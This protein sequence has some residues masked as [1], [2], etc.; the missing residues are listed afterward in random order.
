MSSFWSGWVLILTLACLGLVIFILFATWKIQRKNTTEETVGHEFDGIVEYDNPM[1][2]WWIGLFLATLIFGGIY[3]VLYPGIFPGKFDGILGWTSIGELEGDQAKHKEQF[4]PLFS[5][6]ANMS[7]EE[8]QSEP[9][10]LNMGKRIFL[11]NCA[12]C[13]G[14]DAG[15]TFGFPSLTDD[16]WVWGGSADEIE[17]TV[18]DG[19]TGQMP[20]WG[21]VLGEK[22][23]RNVSLYARSLSGIDTGAT[24]K[25]LQAGKTAYD[26]TC[27]VCHGADGKGN[28]LFGAPNLTDDVWL[29]GS[30]QAQVE[31][32]VRKGRNG[33]M[34][35]WKD[36]LGK[37]KVHLVTGYVYSLTKDKK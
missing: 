31:Y 18:L 32:T 1:P 4:Q 17:T 12:L 22:G 33:V 20:A 3:F 14:S 21:P 10:A 29:F 8:L 34:P 16:D 19:R 5:K 27:A 25:E 30:S 2:M 15:G 36:V 11:N 9:Q 24:S 37:D 35:P 23:V 26:T 6:Y 7:I 13:H 28:K